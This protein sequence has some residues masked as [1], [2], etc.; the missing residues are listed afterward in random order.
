MREDDGGAPSDGFGDQALARAAHRARITARRDPVK[1]CD[2]TGVMEQI[3]DN[4][5]K[6]STGLDTHDTMARRL[7]R[8]RYH[9]HTWHHLMLTINKQEEAKTIERSEM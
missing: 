8:R 9:R 6:L 1:V 7:P 4:V 3:A 5:T 2:F